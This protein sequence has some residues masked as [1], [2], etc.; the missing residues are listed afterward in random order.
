MPVVP[1]AVHVLL[2]IIVEI[3]VHKDDPDI[4][5]R[6]LVAHGEIVTIG[7]CQ[8]ESAILQQ[9][10]IVDDSFPGIHGLAVDRKQYVAA[11]GSLAVSP[12]IVAIHF[13]IKDQFGKHE[14]DHRLRHT[15]VIVAPLHTVRIRE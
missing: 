7:I 1:G 6:L 8:S 4:L 11:I 9:V 10:A 12:V 15:P 3:L 13:C 14:T 2:F 5:R